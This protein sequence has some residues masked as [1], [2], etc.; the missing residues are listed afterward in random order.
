MQQRT[1]GGLISRFPNQVRLLPLVAGAAGFACLL[2]NRSLSK[3]APVM[4]A[5]SPQSRVDI[6]IIGL[7][8]CLALSG[9]QWLSVKPAV[10]MPVRPC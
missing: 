6:L 8:A 7:A 10:R 4:D 9:F 5:S 1:Q 3:V 2:A